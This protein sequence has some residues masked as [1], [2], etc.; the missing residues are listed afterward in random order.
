MNPNKKIFEFDFN[1]DAFARRAPQPS[2]TSQQN[3]KILKEIVEKHGNADYELLERKDLHQIYQ[4]FIR[5]GQTDKLRQEFDSPKRIRQLTWVLTFSDKNQQRIVDNPSQLQNALQLIEE[6]SSISHLPGVFNALLE[7]WGTQ[8]T[9]ILRSFIKKQLTDYSGKRKFAQELKT[10][11]AWYCEENSATQFAMELLRSNWKLSDVWSLLELPEYMNTYPYFGAVA[12]A[13]ISLIRHLD[14]EV[15]ADII[16]FLEK[17]NNDDT[18][19]LILS[20]VIVKL[21]L[22]A[23]ERVRAPVQSYVLRQWEDPRI[24]GA[25]VKWRGVSS[26]ARKIFTKWITEADL[27]FFFDIVAKACNDDKFAYRKA[28]WMAYLEHITFCRP[29]LRENIEKLIQDNIEAIQFYRERQPATLKGGSSNQHAF[30]IQMGEYTF[31]EFSTNAACYVYHSSEMSFRLDSSE[32]TMNTSYI[33][34]DITLRNTALVD[35]RVNHVHSKRYSWQDKFASRIYN[36]LGIRPL[37][38]YRI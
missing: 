31:V 8:N 5:T 20:D 2:K 24:A 16:N 33:R 27:E 7:T 30:I 19:R 35:L 13:F 1:P 18:S 38:S 34:S 14:R 25:D 26:E 28:F 17:H 11:M 36:K 3:I 12:K 21:G 9:K 23:S 22:D 10:N 15:F 37:R 32:Y 29:V 4:L 6:R